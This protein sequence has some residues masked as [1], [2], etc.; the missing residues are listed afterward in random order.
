VEAVGRSLGSCG[1]FRQSILSDFCDNIQQMAKNARAVQVAAV[2]SQRQESAGVAVATARGPPPSAHPQRTALDF[3]MDIL[4]KRQGALA[5]TLKT[6][7][8]IPR[9]L[10][11]MRPG[12]DVPALGGRGKQAKEQ[13]PMDKLVKDMPSL[14][15]LGMQPEEHL[16]LEELG[17][18][19][20]ALDDLG[21]DVP[22]LDELGKQP[23][24][25]LTMDVPALDEL[26]EDCQPWTSWGRTCQP[27]M[28]W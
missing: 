5:A 17:K 8:A 26:L 27:W 12:V 9:P 4:E 11:R 6:G 21:V 15:E 20:L 14:D 25:Q 22:A 19:V 18:N 13:L 23:K 7:S 1:G 16:P 3:A 28:S 24:E 2:Q 10:R